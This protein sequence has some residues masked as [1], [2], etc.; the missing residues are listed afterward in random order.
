LKVL[1]GEKTLGKT[2]KKVKY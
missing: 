1:T 2:F